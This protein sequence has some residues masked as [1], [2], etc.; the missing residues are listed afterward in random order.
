MN[1]EEVNISLSAERILAATLKKYEI[2]LTPEE[3]MDDFSNYQIE[4]LQNEDGTLLFG[5]IGVDDE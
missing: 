4:V 2:L 1:E 5:L 3:L